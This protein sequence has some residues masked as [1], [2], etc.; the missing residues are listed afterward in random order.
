M[1]DEVTQPEV[2]QEDVGVKEILEVLEG[3]KEVGLLAK[4]AMADGKISISDFPLLMQLLSKHQML[5]DAIKD[6]KLVPTEVKNLSG[7]EATLI[8]GKVYSIFSEIKNA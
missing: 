4:K 2:V 8:V 1:G 7:D 3:L 6:I 5:N